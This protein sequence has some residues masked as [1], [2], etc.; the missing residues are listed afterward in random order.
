M[1]AHGSQFFFISSSEIMVSS[2]SQSL[3][4]RSQNLF[5]TYIFLMKCV[6][7]GIESG[8]KVLFLPCYRFSI[9]FNNFESFQYCDF[10]NCLVRNYEINYLHNMLIF[11][12]FCRWFVGILDRKRY[13]CLMLKLFRDVEPNDILW[14]HWKENFVHSGSF[15]LKTRIFEKKLCVQTR[16]LGISVRNLH[17]L[18]TS[19]SD[20]EMG[21]I[22]L[23]CTRWC[24]D[25]LY[26]SATESSRFYLKN[27]IHGFRIESV[28]SPSSCPSYCLFWIYSWLLNF[29]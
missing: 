3:I 27:L 24:L 10:M 2:M 25:T 9:E 14:E 13:E 1:H 15:S 4:D 11:C 7:N 28:A 20:A 18:N 22:Q 17:L 19:H 6:F 29:Y 16:I 5:S 23:F 26:D 8:S 12:V 21:L